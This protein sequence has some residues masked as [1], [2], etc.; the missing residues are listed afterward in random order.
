MPGGV[1][2]IKPE[3]IIFS[4]VPNV[5]CQLQRACD[6]PPHDQHK[7]VTCEHRQENGRKDLEQIDRDSH[8]AEKFK[9]EMRLRKDEPE[10][11]VVGKKKT[12]AA[13]DK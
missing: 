13:G 12:R 10:L 2:E 1:G 7:W 5:D 4:R 9:I 6:H 3:V 11:G 8:D